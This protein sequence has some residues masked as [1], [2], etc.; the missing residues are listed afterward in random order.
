MILVLALVCVAHANERVEL[1]DSLGDVLSHDSRIASVMSST[2]ATLGGALHS[3]MGRAR[4]DAHT[5]TTHSTA[6]RFKVAETV[7]TRDGIGHEVHRSMKAQDGGST[8]VIANKNFMAI[9]EDANGNPLPPDGTDGQQQTPSGSS[10]AVAAPAGSSSAVAPAPVSASASSSAAPAVSGAPRFQQINRR[11][12]A[13]RSRHV[14]AVKRAHTAGKAA[15]AHIRRQKS[16][17]ELEQEASQQNAIAEVK[18]ALED[19]AKT[20]ARNALHD[21]LKARSRSKNH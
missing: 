5:T 18:E 6:G 7:R 13:H 8:T 11:Q 1:G 15:R 14:A 19:A 17:Q 4:A 16:Q 9:M 10:S 21:A 12:H 2:A 20:N 3:S